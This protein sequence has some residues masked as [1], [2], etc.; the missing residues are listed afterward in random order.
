MS[1]QPNRKRARADREEREFDRTYLNEDT[2]GSRVHRDYAAHWFRWGF[3][4][5]RFV[6]PFG[7]A[8]VLDIGCGPD[9]PFMKVLFH[10][11]QLNNVP[12]W[13]EGV[14]LNRI[15]KKPG[16]KRAMIHDEFNFIERWQEL[17]ERETNGFDLIT[18]FEVIEHMHV[19]DG[20]K[21]L[22]AARQLLAPEG[23]FLLSTPVFDG[24]GKARNHIHEYTV[25]EL[26][27]AIAAAGLVVEKR[28]GTFMNAQAVPKCA[29]PEE[30]DVW[31]RLRTYYSDEVLACFLAPL[32][33]DHS[34]NNVWLLRR[35]VA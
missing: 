8:S 15:P 20:A 26:Q 5:S 12:R 30:L 35:S 18:C 16:L 28:F 23:V 1:D 13:Y 32:H 34:R 22:S 14:D 33:P 21:L 7:T 3:A 11:A 4:A 29:T 25:E 19:P 31:R 2:H 17:L 9:L 24:K 6:R 10:T 27:A